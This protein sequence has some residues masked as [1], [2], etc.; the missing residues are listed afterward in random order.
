MN[1]YRKKNIDIYLRP[2]IIVVIRNLP[3][4]SVT[5]TPRQNQSV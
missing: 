2:G 3:L 4:A 1:Y 5:K